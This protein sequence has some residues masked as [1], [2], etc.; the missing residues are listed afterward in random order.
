[1]ARR[2]EKHAVVVVVVI[3]E[4]TDPHW[5]RRTSL[6][7][8]RQPHEN[9]QQS[10]REQQPRGA[11]SHEPGTYTWDQRTVN[12]QFGPRWSRSARAA[13]TVAFQRAGALAG[14]CR[15]AARGT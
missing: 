6:G 15:A 2:D 11:A 1:M 7:E 14:W 13:W 5:I 8:R 3:E 12:S 9:C 10:Q 4:A